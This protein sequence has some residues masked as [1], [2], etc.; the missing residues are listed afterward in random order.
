MGI[1]QRALDLR[2]KLGWVKWFAT[3]F[4][5][6]RYT[7]DK[8]VAEFLSYLNSPLATVSGTGALSSAVSGF[9]SRKA[10]LFL[11][12]F[13][14]DDWDLAVNYYRFENAA[15]SSNSNS[16][17]F[18]LGHDFS[19][20]WNAAIGIRRDVPEQQNTGYLYLTHIL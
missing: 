16:L 1:S 3:G 10:E 11:N 5:V 20:T 17:K 12:W 14:V 15:D 2:V 18:I 4:G 7:Y 6:T 13:F 8:S 9:S 19:A